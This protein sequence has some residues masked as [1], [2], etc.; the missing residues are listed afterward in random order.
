MIKK[1]GKSEYACL[2]EFLERDIGRNYFILLAFFSE[3]DIYDEI[4]VEYVE[5]EILAAL[6]KRKSKNLQFFGLGDFSEDKFVDLIKTMDYK[7]LIGPRSFCDKFLNKGIF[8]F[9]EDGAYIAELDKKSKVPEVEEDIRKIRI[10]DLNEIVDLYKENF[11]SFASKE[12]MKE[13]LRTKR[14]RGVCIEREGKIVS[15]AQTDFE[16]KD[17]ALIV[18]VATAEEYKAKGLATL[19]LKKLCKMLLEE[20]KDIYL[21]YDN[22]E[23][24]KIYKRLGFKE[25]DQVRHYRKQS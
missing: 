23:A 4:Y 24:G 2:K 8:D 14:G 18:G 9:Y 16:K 1:I 12:L 11:K 25:I 19:C 5:G 6:F 22:L 15:L 20:G 3:K 21:Q 7:A 17:K 13:K 10:S